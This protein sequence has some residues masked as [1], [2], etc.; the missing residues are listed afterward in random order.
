MALGYKPRLL[1]QPVMK[2]YCGLPKVRLCLKHGRTLLLL[3]V[4]GKVWDQPFRLHP[5]SAAKGLVL[6]DRH[7]FRWV[8]QLR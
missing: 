8:G 7:D 5:D 3:L 2:R 4:T 6:P 1:N